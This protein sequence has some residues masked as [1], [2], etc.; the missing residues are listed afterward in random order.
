MDTLTPA[1]RSERMS[2]VKN[3]NT[4]VEW[5]VRRLIHGLGYRY[6]LHRTNLPGKP[7]LVFAS[8]RKVI[9]VH[10][11]FWHMHSACKLARMPKS[12]LEFWQ[13]KLERNR[14]RD[15]QV[16]CDLKKLNWEAMVIWECELRDEEKLAGRIHAFLA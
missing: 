7:D 8:R 11:C 10:G 14:E 2:R 3:K 12:R 13:P 1:G 4:A 6:R 15:R 16:Q 5:R 9:F